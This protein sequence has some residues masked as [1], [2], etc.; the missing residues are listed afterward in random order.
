[1]PLWQCARKLRRC[2]RGTGI[3]SAAA[4]F[5]GSNLLDLGSVTGHWLLVVTGVLWRLL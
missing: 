2:R 4:E 5:D 1:M 3:C